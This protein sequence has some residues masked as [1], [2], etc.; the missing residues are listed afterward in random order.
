MDCFTPWSGAATLDMK[1]NPVAGKYPDRTPQFITNRELEQYYE[2]KYA[3]SGYTEHGRVVFGINVSKRYHQ[4]KYVS[5]LAFLQAGTGETILDAGC[6]DGALSAQ[7][8]PHCKAVHAIDVAGNAFARE[9]S[10]IP[11]VHFAKMNIE[12]L[13]FHDG[14]F[15]KIVCVEALEHVLDPEKAVAEFYR[16]LRPG[17]LLVLTYP[18][19]N[20]SLIR[21]ILQKLKLKEEVKMYE[22]LSE[23]SYDDVIKNVTRA[24][25][26]FVRGQGIAFE[27]LLL[28]WAQ[29]TT[30]AIAQKAL[31]LSL[32][33]KVFPRNSV[34]IV[35][36]FRKPAVP[37]SPP[38]A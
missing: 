19:I 30:K 20:R 31:D 16:A 3:Q 17:G 9:Y 2:S 7:M 27:L 35:A 37:Q 6:G 28:S 13:A 34:F 23:W 24:G 18:T 25:F 10:G 38:K 22:H 21:T 1:N 8:A 36:S 26:E 33:I 29:H 12:E 32:A 4:Q 15:D 5:A 14:F 11:N